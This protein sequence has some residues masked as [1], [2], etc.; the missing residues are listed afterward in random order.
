MKNVK[1]Y[2]IG[3]L[4]TIIGAVIAI[5]LGENNPPN[6]LHLIGLFIGSISVFYLI[7]VEIIRFSI[8]MLKLLGYVPKN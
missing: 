3:V 4:G 6:G 1:P 7:I 2:L 8:Y 5:Y